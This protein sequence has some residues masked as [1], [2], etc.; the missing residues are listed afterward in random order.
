MSS[1]KSCPETKTASGSQYLQKPR[2]AAD[3][4]G[5]AGAGA[6]GAGTGTCGAA[7]HGVNGAVGGGNCCG[8]GGTPAGGGGTDGQAGAIGGRISP[9]TRAVPSPFNG[10]HST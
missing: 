8:G 7:G 4:G 10:I 1:F 3:D 5:N 6:A 9:S 2:G